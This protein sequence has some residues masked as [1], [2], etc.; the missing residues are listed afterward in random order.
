MITFTVYGSPAPQGSKKFVGLRKKGKRAGTAILV[1]MSKKLPGWRAAVTLAAKQVSAGRPMLT[2]PLEVRMVFTMPKP[3][4]APKRKRTYPAVTPDGSKLQRST[5]DALTDAGVWKD[6]A[7]VV[8][9]SGAKVY[10]GEHP[11][12]LGAPGVRITI[13]PVESC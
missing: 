13:R 10:P 1:E 3:V 8:Y 6:D 9:W 7:L 11:E 12:A 2:G 4:S 5:E